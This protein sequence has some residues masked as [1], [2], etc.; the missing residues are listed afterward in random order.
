MHTQAETHLTPRPLPTRHTARA[1]TLIELLVVISIIALLIGILLPALASAREAARAAACMAHQRGT[2]QALAAYTTEFNGYMPGQNTSGVRLMSAGDGGDFNTLQYARASG[3]HALQTDDWMSPLF[4]DILGLPAKPEDRMIQ[5]FAF[6]MRCPSMELQY[7]FY[8]SG[9]TM[10]R[11]Q[12][13]DQG[14]G[15][16]VNSYSMSTTWQVRRDGRSGNDVSD[17]DGCGGTHPVYGVPVRAVNLSQVD[18][19][20][21]RFNFRIDDVGNLSG[22]TFASEGVRYT[23]VSAGNVTFTGDNWTSSG[24]TN[25]SHLGWVYTGSGGN[26]YKWG[27][28]GA[29]STNGK[30][31]GDM[32][33]DLHPLSRDV[34]FRHGSND[35]M[36]MVQFDGSGGIVPVDEGA[37]INR[38]L[39]SGTV[40]ANRSNL[41]ADPNDTN[42]Q[43]ID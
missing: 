23:D 34:A 40:M 18:R 26:P 30:S 19:Y 16:P 25:F 38:H 27:N 31:A 21:T 43:V 22:K 37:D 28:N 42:G 35:S 3:R 4:G 41:T 1:F 15:L 12:D 7:E 11:K 8:S 6:E 39:P 24:G 20:P 36:A 9:S 14:D 5:L 32:R 33:K 13:L 29:S 17:G 2:G 10:Y